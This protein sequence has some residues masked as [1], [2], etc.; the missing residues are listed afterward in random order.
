MQ[1]AQDPPRL[2]IFSAT[3]DFLDT[4]PR[5]AMARAI[6]AHQHAEA[7]EGEPFET[8]HSWDGVLFRLR[9]N[10]DRSETDIRLE[11]EP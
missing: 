11:G 9:T 1:T 4:V 10:A 6:L 2:G 7:R 3:P 5:D 8:R